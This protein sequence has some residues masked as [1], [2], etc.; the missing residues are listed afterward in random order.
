MIHQ[1]QK[2]EVICKPIGA[3]ILFQVVGNVYCSRMNFYL[4]SSITVKKED[5]ICKKIFGSVD[6]TNKFLKRNRT[7]SKVIF[8]NDLGYDNCDSV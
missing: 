6:N 1:N 5:S 2:V 8:L 3:D 7:V 4:P